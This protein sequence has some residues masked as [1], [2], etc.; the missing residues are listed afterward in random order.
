VIV[1]DAVETLAK[2]RCEEGKPREEPI[3]EGW[4]VE[5]VHQT[6][7]LHDGHTYIVAQK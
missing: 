5:R 7:G 4:S 6:V 3:E 2:H 1:I